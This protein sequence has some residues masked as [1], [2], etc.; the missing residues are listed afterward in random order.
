MRV[1]HYLVIGVIAYFLF[2]VVNIPAS[3]IVH[4]AAGKSPQLSFQYASGTL[5]NGSAQ[6][7]TINNRYALNDVNW[8]FKLWRLLTAEAAVDFDASFDNRPVSGQFGIGITGAYVA[9][10]V[11]AQISASTLGD[12]IRL[13]LGELSGMIDLDLSFLRWSGGPALTAA[14]TMLWNKAAITVAERVELG[15]VSLEFDEADTFPLLATI[16][17][18]GGNLSLSG[19]GNI[20]DA[21]DYSIELK[22]LPENNAS[23]N[24]R[25]SLAMF[26]KKQTNGSF[27]IKN[28]GNLTQLGL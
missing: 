5:W 20:N 27:I 1:K 21:G 13:P 4:W 14:G 19:D 24:L 11:I 2:L 16:S 8:S 3:P 25:K 17:N 22:L 18:Q 12:L 6:Q 15:R 28:S 9:R 10:D 7:V 23:D 26:A